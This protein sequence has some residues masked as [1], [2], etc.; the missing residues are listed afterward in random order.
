MCLESVM[1]DYVNI[2]KEYNILIV[3]MFLEIWINITIKYTLN[4]CLETDK[5]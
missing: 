1:F 2:I 3:V 4:T 5:S